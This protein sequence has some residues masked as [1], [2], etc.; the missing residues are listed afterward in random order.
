MQEVTHIAHFMQ[1][2][3]LFSKYFLH[4]KKEN[5]LYKAV[6]RVVFAVSLPFSKHQ[7]TLTVNHFS[8]I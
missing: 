6:K 7:G 3:R 4:L 2:Y 8:S 1:Y 5:P